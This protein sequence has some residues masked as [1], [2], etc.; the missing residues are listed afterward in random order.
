[1]TGLLIRDAELDGVVLDVRV[2]AGRVRELGRKLP[3]ASGG[4]RVV[5]ARGGALLPG[6]TDHHLHLYATAADLASLPCGPAA[7]QD[8]QGLAEALR[9]AAPDTHGWIRGVRYHESVAGELDAERLDRLR[10]DLPVRVQHR[11]GALWVLNSRAMNAVGLHT[12]EHPGVER[13]GEGRP[14]GRLWRADDW[15]RTRL[16]ATAP[17]SLAELGRRLA[18]YGITAVTDATPRLDQGTIDALTEAVA[19]GEVP[20]RVQVLGAPLDGS[21]RPDRDRNGPEPGPW[22]IVLADSGLPDL[23]QLTLAIDVAHRA[24]RPVAVHCVT[25]VSL[26]LLLAAL[27]QVGTLPGDRLEHASLI[28]AEVLP[29]IRELG[30]SVVTQPGFL[31]DR[32]DAYLSGTPADEHG[33][34]YRCASLRAAGVPLGLS[35]DAPYGPL[36][37]WAVMRAAVQRDT[38][39]GAVVA[40]SERLGP[41]QALEGYLSPARWPGSA[42]HRIEGGRRAD[43]VL[44]HTPLA[45]ALAHLDADL[46]R[47]VLIGGRPVY[48]DGDTGSRPAGRPGQCL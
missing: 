4:E 44:L 8:A 10:D 13:D 1:M 47:L 2:G 28:P 26:L 42:P 48:E 14:T 12:A 6:L 37:P 34:L 32:G 5:Q 7:V 35:S 21:L 20:Q 3:R 23:E 41:A 39:S 24:G 38:P 40:P 16:P 29:T 33:D 30:L 18:R 46:V 19:V 17:P 45:E 36:D 22:K 43:L 31:A 11:S 15:L 9:R 25:R 27:E